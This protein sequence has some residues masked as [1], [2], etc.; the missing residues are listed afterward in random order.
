[1]SNSKIAHVTKFSVNN[2]KQ[3]ICNYN[4][5]QKKNLIKLF[6]K[7]IE[8]YVWIILDFESFIA[9]FLT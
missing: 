2:S 6:V 8:R 3:K 1:M 5:F 4:I 9:E 7:V